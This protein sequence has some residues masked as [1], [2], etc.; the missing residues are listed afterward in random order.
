M[1]RIAVAIAVT[2][3]FAAS[4][5][6]R[7]SSAVR[8][9]G[10]FNL[11]GTWA[12]NCSEAPSP[13]NPRVTVSRVEQGRVLEQHDFGPDY[14]TNRY[15]VVTARR[16]GRDRLAVEAMFEQGDA[17]PQRQRII[18]RVERHRRR[19]LFNGSEGE[20]PRVKDGIAVAAGTPTPLLVKCE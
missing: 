5:A 6:A 2:V 15:V 11:F 14:E 20:P 10:H 1:V 18:L 9:F 16:I 12:P 8:E 3:I 4:A 13:D 7:P 19:T 17:E